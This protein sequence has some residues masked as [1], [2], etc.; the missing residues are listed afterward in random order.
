MTDFTTA[1]IHSALSGLSVRQ[2]ATADNIANIQ[3]PGYLAGRVDF[4]SS[5]RDALAGRTSAVEPSMTRS[6]SPTRT[7][8]NN[9][10]LDTE[11][12]SMV[13]TNLKYQ[14]MVEAMNHKFRLLRTSIGG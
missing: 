3:T 11:T 7:D 10:N 6:L 8:G 5:L 14:T 13:E 4:E 12:L 2:K 9:V 1:A